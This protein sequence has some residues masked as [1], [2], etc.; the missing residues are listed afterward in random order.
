MIQGQI[1]VHN[2]SDN[3]GSEEIFFAAMQNI[4]SSQVFQFAFNEKVDKQWLLTEN[5][6]AWQTLETGA[7]T[8]IISTYDNLD[9]DAVLN[10]NLQIDCTANVLMINP[11]K[12]EHSQT[13]MLQSS[14]MLCICKRS[15]NML[16]LL[17]TL[18][19]FVYILTVQSQQSAEIKSKKK[20]MFLVR[21]SHVQESPFS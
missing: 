11:S 12:N 15:T 16:A 10:N 2:V 14:N 19:L 18:R 1:E 6:T 9:I 21:I 3:S 7:D 4:C 20:T 13:S 17:F 8:T 5:P